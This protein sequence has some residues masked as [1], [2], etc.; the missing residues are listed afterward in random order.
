MS[1]ETGRVTFADNLKGFGFIRRVAGKDAFFPYSEVQG[2]E[3]L[4]ELFPGDTVTFEI[5]K[6]KK[7]PKAVKVEKA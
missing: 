5:I 4:A 7:G 1:R 6:E 2:F 3:G